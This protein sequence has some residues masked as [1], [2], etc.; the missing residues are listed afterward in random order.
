[1]LAALEGGA[2]GGGAGVEFDDM[3]RSTALAVRA[4][5]V[6]Y[7]ALG[8]A[9]GCF[10]FARRDAFDAAGGWDER[11][12]ASEEVHLS[13]ALRKRGRFVILRE[14]VV[15]SARKARMH[16]PL[17][18]LWRSIVLTLRG[19]AGARRRHGLELWYDGKR[20]EATGR[21]LRET[22]DRDAGG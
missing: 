6:V 21:L 15:S 20:E 17:Q 1:M 18:L 12:F 9:A 10:L 8:L 3:P 13:W 4:F 7:Q 11:Y 2:A 16:P 5:L 22:A 19:P 14:R